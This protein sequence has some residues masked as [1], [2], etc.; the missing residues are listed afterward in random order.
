MAGPKKVQKWEGKSGEL[1]DTRKA[2]MRDD[3]IYDALQFFDNN[4]ITPSPEGDV[5][6][7]EM[8]EYLNTYKAIILRYYGVV[9]PTLKG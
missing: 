7:N 2:A 1:F 3:E 9:I 8:K 5:G 6:G 4:P